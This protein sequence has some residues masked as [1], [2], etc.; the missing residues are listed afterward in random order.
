[1]RV[2][3]EGVLMRVRN[4]N[5]FGQASVSLNRD[6]FSHGAGAIFGTMSV[7]FEGL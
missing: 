6:C 4:N 7:S 2:D 5:W 3:G 1:M